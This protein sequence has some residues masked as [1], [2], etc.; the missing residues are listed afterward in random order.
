MVCMNDERSVPCW[1]PAAHTS[2]LDRVQANH[3]CIMENFE[4]F[5]AA[6]NGKRLAVFLDYDGAYVHG[7]ARIMRA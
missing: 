4:Q 7:V 6:L 2:N 1:W 5:K 3:P